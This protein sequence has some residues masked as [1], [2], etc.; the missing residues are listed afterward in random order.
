M[1]HRLE[2]ILFGPSPLKYLE[3]CRLP[4]LILLDP[5]PLKF[6][7]QC[8]I[9]SSV[10]SDPSSL[11][12]G[13]RSPSPSSIVSQVHRPCLTLC[14]LRLNFCTMTT[15]SRLL[16]F[17]PNLRRLETAI[18]PSS[19]YLQ[20]TNEHVNLKYLK[21]FLRNNVKLL[22]LQ[23]VL[24]RLSS[25]ET[26]H[27]SSYQPGVS[28]ERFNHRELINLL[29]CQL[30]RLEEMLRRAASLVGDAEKNVKGLEDCQINRSRRKN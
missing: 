22:D 29:A 27:L 4:T 16:T 10:L 7:E 14:S 8:R 20:H 28:E 3:R 12:P 21:V 18:V 11:Q 2:T 17:L 13:E 6:L 25:L 1:D 24:S 5:S 15:C 23:P 9:S 19:I 26:L 30:A